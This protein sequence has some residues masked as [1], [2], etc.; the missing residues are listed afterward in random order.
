MKYIIDRIEEGILVLE[1]EGKN[2]I[3]FKSTDKIKNIE[4]FKEGDVIEINDDGTITLLY[5]ET[6]K[7]RK[8]IEE[9]ISSLWE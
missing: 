7:R 9:K 5:E 6:I 4:N 2:M 3:D 8:E 1:D